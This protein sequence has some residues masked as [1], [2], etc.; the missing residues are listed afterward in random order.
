V[1]MAIHE[2]VHCNDTTLTPLDVVGGDGVN[3]MDNGQC[4]TWKGVNA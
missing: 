2:R 4:L 3:G 1:K